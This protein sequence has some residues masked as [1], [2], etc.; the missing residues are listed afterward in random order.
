MAM[1]NGRFTSD[2]D[3][4]R[5]MRGDRDKVSKKQASIFSVFPA[6]YNLQTH[7]ALRECTCII[8]ILTHTHTSS[9]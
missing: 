9:V 8:I 6:L 4:V 5:L 3:F 7:T 1:A 2:D